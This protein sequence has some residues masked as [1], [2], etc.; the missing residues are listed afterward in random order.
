MKDIEP[1]SPNLRPST[2][3]NRVKRAI[4]N[5]ENYIENIV[6]SGEMPSHFSDDAF[7]I[8]MDAGAELEKYL[9]ELSCQVPSAEIIYEDVTK[10]GEM[11]WISCNPD[12]PRIWSLFHHERCSAIE[13]MKG[14]EGKNEYYAKIYG[15]KNRMDA[16]FDIA[17]K[18]ERE[19]VF[20]WGI[21]EMKI[22]DRIDITN[23]YDAKRISLKLYE[24]WL[25]EKK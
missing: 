22:G 5:I 23:I 20:T 19:F 12:R 24:I 16:R 25:K 14:L 6:K 21:E 13:R 7:N 18:W 2:Y 9:V 8:L 11:Y 17:E 15:W 1:S 10:D 3:K 4:K